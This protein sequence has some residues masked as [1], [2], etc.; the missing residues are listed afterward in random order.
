MA[1]E[2][3]RRRIEQLLDEAEE[4][5]TAVTRALSLEPDNPDAQALLEAVERAQ[6]S[7]FASNVSWLIL[8]VLFQD[9]EKDVLH[10]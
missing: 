7:S 1:T 8:A 2:R 3:L 6:D 4:A 9:H 10:V 5:L